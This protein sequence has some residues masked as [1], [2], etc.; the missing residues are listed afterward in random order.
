[1]R[2]LHRSFWKCSKASQ[3]CMTQPGFLL[4]V[5]PSYFLLSFSSFLS[6]VTFISVPLFK[7]R[8]HTYL[9]ALSHFMSVS[10]RGLMTLQ[11]DNLTRVESLRAGAH[12]DGFERQNNWINCF[13]DIR[14]IKLVLCY[15][16]SLYF[17][18]CFC[19]VKWVKVTLA[20][21]HF[22]TQRNREAATRPLK[23]TDSQCHLKELKKRKINAHKTVI[24]LTL[25]SFHHMMGIEFK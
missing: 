19:V 5:R 15:D 7:T 12:R 10:L 18:D 22:I 16:V 2:G 3:S 4:S 13:V 8:S 24:R 23:S 21:T 14:G 20:Q 9:L 11:T 6:C 1:M 17:V 25:G